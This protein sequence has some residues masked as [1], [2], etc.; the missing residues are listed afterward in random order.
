MVVSRDVFIIEQIV[1][2][3]EVCFNPLM[4]GGNK[5]VTHLNKA[6][7]ETLIACLDMITFY[8]LLTH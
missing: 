6:A 1:N 2:I 4:P 7:A 3:Y 5:K 8:S